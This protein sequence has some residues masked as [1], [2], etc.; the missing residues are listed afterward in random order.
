MAKNNKQQSY[1]QVLKREDDS[2]FNTKNIYI[3]TLLCAVL[4]VLPTSDITKGDKSISK[5]V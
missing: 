1:V 2:K 4:L 5:R 3:Y